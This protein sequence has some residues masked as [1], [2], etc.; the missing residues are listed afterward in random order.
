MKIEISIFNPRLNK[1]MQLLWE[2]KDTTTDDKIQAM[3][4]DYTSAMTV[5][6]SCVSSEER[7][8]EKEN[9][10]SWTKEG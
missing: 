5:W 8:F 4:D 9:S 10:V 1:S 6:D 2:V 7:F 3:I